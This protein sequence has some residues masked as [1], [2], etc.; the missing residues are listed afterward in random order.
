MDDVSLSKKIAEAVRENGGRTFYVGGYVRD[1]LLSIDNKDVDIEVHGIEHDKL[2]QIISQFGEVKTFGDS[3]GIFSLKYHNIDIA[4]PRSEENT[5]RGHRDFAIYVDPFIGYE[6]A[7]RRRDFTIN[8]LMEDVLTGEILDY[9]DG[10]KDLEDRIIRHVDR[11]SFVEDPLRV[12]RAAQFSSRFEFAVAEETVELCRNIDLTAL[13]KERIEEELKKALLKSKKPSIFFDVLS[14]MDQLSYWFK[15]IEEIKN[16]EQDRSYHPEGDVYIHTMEVLD[17]CSMYRDLVE[18]PYYFM[19]S[20]LCHDLGKITTTVEINGRIHAY[21][22]E[23]EGVRI[24]GVFVHRISTNNSLLAYVKNMVYLHMKP[25]T[26]FNDHSKIKSSNKMFDEAK[27]P[28]DLIYLALADRGGDVEEVK[29]FLF[30][31]YEIYKE[32]MARPFVKGEDLKKAGIEPCPDF[33]KYI[34]YARKLRLAGLEKNTA[35]K[36]TLDYIKNHKDE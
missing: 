9:F 11:D 4:L 6:K 35:L 18:E 36:Q 20:G 34:A 26:M 5:G 32:Y 33:H 23:K 30:D 15:E 27:Y 21:G 16:I 2:Y 17:R 14:K 12:L 22:H 28:V 24:A 13:S 19:M 7:A 29:A 1:R 10:R 25:N 3:F 8:A 31:R